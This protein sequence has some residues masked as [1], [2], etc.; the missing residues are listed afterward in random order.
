MIRDNITVDANIPAGF[1]IGPN[2]RM[3]IHTLTNLDRTYALINI[4]VNLTF[5]PPELINHPPWSEW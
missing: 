2:G 5:T 3:I 4:P 1:L